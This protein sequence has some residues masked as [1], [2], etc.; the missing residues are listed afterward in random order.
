MPE[1]HREH[2][3][4]MWLNLRRKHHLTSADLDVLA[5]VMMLATDSSDGRSSVSVAGGEEIASEIGASTRTVRASI[6]RL[7]DAGLMSIASDRVGGRGMKSVF[8]VH[9][10]NIG[11]EFSGPLVSVEERLV[12]RAVRPKSYAG[13][14]VSIG[15]RDGFA[16]RICGSTTKDLQIDHI[17]PVSAGGADEISNRQLLCPSCNASKSNAWEV[18]R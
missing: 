18:A 5:T 8:V 14:L 17:K 2:P 11:H 16:C 12:E 10:T 9:W 4:R 13:L 6:G 3:F 7:A 1:N 15:R